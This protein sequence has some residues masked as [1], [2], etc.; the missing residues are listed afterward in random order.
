[1]LGLLTL[2]A[3][4][5]ANDCSQFSTCRSCLNITEGAT[6]GGRNNCGWCHFPIV[7]GAGGEGPRCAD[8]RNQPEGDSPFHCTD[9]YDTYKCQAGYECDFSSGKCS[10]TTAGEGYSKETCE[11][12]CVPAPAGWKCNL[13]TYTCDQCKHGEENCF[14]QGLVCPNCVAPP[15][16]TYKCDKTSNPSNPQCLE[17][18]KDEPGCESHV[19][20]CRHC[21]APEQMT[22]CDTKTLTCKK[23]PRG[24]EGQVCN[25]TCGHFTPSQLT[26]QTFRGF[27]AH[28]G[29]NMGEWDFSF[30][31]KNRVTI[32][33]PD[34]KAVE[35]EVTSTGPGTMTFVMN[36]QSLSF[37]VGEVRQGDEVNTITLATN[38]AGQPAPASASESMGKPNGRVYVLSSCN[39]WSSKCDFSSVAKQ[40]QADLLELFGDLMATNDPCNKYPTCH[41][42]ITAVEAGVKCGWCMGGFLNYNQTGMTTFHCGG[43]QNGKPAAF[44]CAPRFQT[45][46]CKG[47]SC[48][49]GA[50]QPTC[51]IS[52]PG[53][54]ATNKSCSEVCKPTEMAKCNQ[55]TKKCEPCQQG[56][57]GCTLTKDGCDATCNVPHGKCNVTS[58]QCIQCNPGVDKTCTQTMGSCNQQCSQS[59]TYLQCNQ[60]SK[61]CESCKDASGKGCVPSSQQEC[62][63][64]CSH[65]QPEDKLFKCDY[66]SAL[67]P[68][69]VETVVTDPDGT[70][71][72]MCSQMCKKPKYA[73]CDFSS[74]KCVECEQGEDCKNPMEWCE[75]AARAGYCK[76]PAPT[77]LA[78]NWRGNEI[79][80]NFARG[81]WD[82]KFSDD[83]KSLTMQFFDVKVEQKWTASIAVADPMPNLE[84]GVTALDVT[85]TEAP[86]A[87]ALGVKA[88][89]KVKG[90]FR[91]QDGGQDL[92]KVLYLAVAKGTAAPD[93]FDDAM[94]KG[95]EWVLVG[96]KTAGACDFS[97][98]APAA[99]FE[100]SNLLV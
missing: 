84:A 74:G 7:F 25:A 99:A 93:S 23:A 76:H 98:A 2:G 58:K 5:A 9:L 24:Y 100:W 90:L 48:K 16:K 55:V 57:A 43:Y 27:E 78:G 20:A 79:S 95:S 39:A 4:A 28:K 70:S 14:P 52:D 41:T 75:A 6:T 15:H 83:A 47:F 11:Q 10:L 64:A 32:R 67:S 40:A 30:H 63:K 71:L 60:T 92:F 65:P 68:K 69:C 42:C 36:G 26:N 38:G 8:V 46:D 51:G 1:M 97:K 50:K 12:F 17:C 94:T 13:T 56:A 96:C 34:D 35:A 59:P 53:E 21:T 54:F 61:K 87:N 88:G 77:K 31:G 3:L 85:F 18:K 72:E 37:A 91:V 19:D 62:D 81:E 22:M 73:K 82:V 89:S 33:G 49:W 44:T 86:P 29:F 45:E 66:S 80:R